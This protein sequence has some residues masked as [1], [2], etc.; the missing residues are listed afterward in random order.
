M[1]NTK[2]RILAIILVLCMM[3]SGAATALSTSVSTPFNEVVETLYD[4]KIIQGYPD[5]SFR[6][7]SQI[8]LAELATLL[9]KAFQ[10]EAKGI[11]NQ[12][13]LSS[14]WAYKAYNACVDNGVY[15]ASYASTLADLNKYVSID[16]LLEIL[17]DNQ[18][19][20]VT[21]L[22]EPNTVLTRGLVAEILYVLLSTP[23][24]TKEITIFEL[25]D[26][27]RLMDS[28]RLIRYF[29][30]A[31]YYEDNMI[32][33][34]TLVDEPDVYV[35]DEEYGAFIPFDTES[36]LE[37][38]MYNF[39]AVYDVSGEGKGD[40]IFIV[41]REDADL[42][43]VNDTPF[44]LASNPVDFTNEYNIPFGG[45]LIGHWRLFNGAIVDY[46]N[47]ATRGDLSSSI[48]YYTY[49]WYNS[50]STDSFTFLTGFRTFQQT[51]GWACGLTSA[52]MAM[53]WFDMTHGLNELDL[54]ALR[55]TKEKYGTHRWGGAT[56]V[57]ML[58]NVFDSL[59]EMLGYE[60]WLYESTY[61][62]VDEDGELSDEYLSPEWIQ[63]ML[64]QGKPILL[65]WNSF[66]A[67]WQVIIGYD[68]M[69]TEETADDVIILADPYDTTDHLNDG[70][71]VWSYERMY[72]NWTQNFDRDFGRSQGY[73][74][75][76][77]FVPYPADYDADA[78]KP[79]MG[80]G[81][82]Y[83]VGLPFVYDVNE[84]DEM[85]IPYGRTAQDLEDSDY[86]RTKSER[87]D[88]GLAGAASSD[89]YRQGDHIGSPYY[90]QYDFYNGA[91]GISDTLI[92][93]EGFQ[94]SQ[95]ASEW[96]CGPTSMLIALNWFDALGDETEFTLAALRDNDREG[97]TSLDGMVQILTA[98]DLDFMWYT[99][100][101]LDDDDCIEG[102]C[103]YDGPSDDG[104]FPWL[105]SNGIPII[106]G[107]NE[108]GGHWQIIIGYDDMGTDDTQDDVLILVDPYD[109]TDHLQDGYLI[110]SFE[111]LVY[112]WGAA[113]DSRGGT[114]FLIPIPI[115]LELE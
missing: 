42:I 112:G 58:V 50:T 24:G 81:L 75:P 89:Y 63:D 93:L 66:G 84:T 69:G 72:Y 33:A 79:V 80:D 77:I 2:T 16:L 56:D 111:R 101:D 76:V 87:G 113:F 9:T 49:D 96:T 40:T 21:I 52:F 110:E 109:T 68:N 46:S 97:A 92:L 29:T 90:P 70:V 78:Y 104:L 86:N 99:T 114:V 61:D 22:A 5:G 37:S 73:G 31:N 67:H 12:P 59:N 107:W 38:I 4:Y 54:S 17:H 6:A 41:N 30:L 102:Y 95:Q 3:F 39:V 82:A 15:K 60:A 57:K 98:L 10:L 14:H 71:V 88:N 100:D 55:D 64:G 43:W 23:L 47:V 28:A 18:G 26:S 51:T 94:T 91:Q 62:F 7:D 74:M 85:L 45:R 1:K 105:L 108:W 8:T 11:N 27:A 35:Y 103:L 83:S 36:I 44:I 48:Y 32:N 115:G 106:I 13:G 20:D 34:D 19:W 65:G 25:F 53:D